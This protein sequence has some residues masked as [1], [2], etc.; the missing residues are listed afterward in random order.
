M[1][2]LHVAAL[3]VPVLVSLTSC[4]GESRSTVSTPTAVVPSATPTPAPT[5]TVA[6]TPTPSPTSTPEPSPPPGNN[7]PTVSVSGGGSCYPSRSRPCSVDVEAVASDPDG[8]ALAYEWS[9]CASGSSRRATCV[10]DS[11]GSHTAKVVVRDGRGGSA[12]ASRASQGTN[13]PPSAVFA[14][15]SPQPSNRSV[16]MLGY[17]Q[18]PDEGGFVCG[19]EYCV[20]GRA[21]G[22][23]TFYSFGCTCLRGLEV[24]VQ[25]TTGP[26]TCKVTLVVQDEWGL[27]GSGT[28]SFQVS[29][30]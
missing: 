6:P 23:C 5:P 14:T 11:P 4:G 18:D 24:H 26:G 22:A 17:T 8:D 29:A 19:R 1:K 30:P 27:R 21:S 28:F 9:G 3:A 16:E 7:P 2:A 12:S 13:R 25:T 10:V 20:E 15:G